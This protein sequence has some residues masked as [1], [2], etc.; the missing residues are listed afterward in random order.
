[1]NHVL[2]FLLFLGADPTPAS[3]PGSV[4]NLPDVAATPG[5]L[6]LV[7]VSGVEADAVDWETLG[8]APKNVLPQYKPGG[9]VPYGLAFATNTPGVWYIVGAASKKGVPFVVRCTVTVGT[10]TP[11]PGPGPGP[12]PTPPTD[13]TKAL[14]AAYDKDAESSRTAS[15]AYLRGVFLLLAATAQTHTEWRT[16]AD[17]MAYE[18]AMAESVGPDPAHP[19]GLWP[20][21]DPKAQ[22]VNLRKAIGDALLAQLGDDKKAADLSAIAAGFGRVAQALQGVK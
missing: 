4:V 13:L 1:M 6:T 10:P 22:V 16:N 11:P 8:P 21:D 9:M 18:K 3:A 17:A 12:G 15:L 14:Q 19:I 2:C 7:D 5:E 20:I